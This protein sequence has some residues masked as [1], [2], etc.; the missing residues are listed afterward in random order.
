MKRSKRSAPYQPLARAMMVIS[1]VAVLA[2]GVTF[3]A[4]QSQAASLTGNS[5][6]TASA[7]LKIGTTATS[8]GSTRTGFS[9]NGLVPGGAAVPADGNTFY[10]KNGGSATLA[11]KVT[12]PAAPTNLTAVDLEKV[13]IT[14]TRVDLPVAS[15]PQKVSI[16]ALVAS[17]AMGGVALTDVLAGTTVGQYKV[18]ASMDAEAFSGQSAEIGGIDLVFSGS[19]V[20]P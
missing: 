9:F 12:V 7:D 15:A 20:T 6:Q 10:L 2:T 5:I 14:V 19:S 11:L 13:Y 1:A 17:Q 8:F 3:A 16:A 4:L 18:Q